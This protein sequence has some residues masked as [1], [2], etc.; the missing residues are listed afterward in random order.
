M[1]RVKLH[2]QNAADVGADRQPSEKGGG[3]S[4]VTASSAAPGPSAI[5]KGSSSQANV[6]RGGGPPSSRIR[7]AS[8]DDRRAKCRGETSRPRK[9][10][11]G[12]VGQRG[13]DVDFLGRCLSVRDPGHSAL[14]CGDGYRKTTAALRDRQGGSAH[15]ARNALA[16]LLRRSSDCLMLLLGQP[17]RHH[18]AHPTAGSWSVRTGAGGGLRCHTRKPTPRSPYSAM[19]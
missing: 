5:R 8:R 18:G 2:H 3:P 16:G 12:R 6:R 13:R 10:A 11:L 14:G 7:A 19:V 4:P 17:D 15:V 1:T 9:P